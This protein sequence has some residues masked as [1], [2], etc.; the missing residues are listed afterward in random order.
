MQSIRGPWPKSYSEQG[1]VVAENLEKHG[2][3][4]R[5]WSPEMLKLYKETWLEVVEEEAAKDAFFK[6]V[7]EDYKA[8]SNQC[9]PYES[10]AHLPRQE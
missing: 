7:W 8:W 10:V 3:Q 9:K 6:K 4:N 2:T 5:E 1:P